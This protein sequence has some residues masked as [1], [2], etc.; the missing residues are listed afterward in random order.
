MTLS[1]IRTFAACL[2]LAAPHFVA[3]AEPAAPPAA[4][5]TAPAYTMSIACFSDTL[6]KKPEWIFVL[7]TVAFRSLDDLKKAI[8]H[9]PKGSTLTWAPGCKRIGGEPLSGE[10]ELNAFR[11]H[12]E[13]HG[14]RFILVPSG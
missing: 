10:G 5:S 8:T 2:V 13:A 9:F 3:A 14:I 11:A 7:G 6:G 12:C 1:T 4:A